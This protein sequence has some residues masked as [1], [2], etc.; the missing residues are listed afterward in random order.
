MLIFIRTTQVK[1]IN[2]KFSKLI[3]EKNVMR[4]ESN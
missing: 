3:I 1:K 4:K 2:Y